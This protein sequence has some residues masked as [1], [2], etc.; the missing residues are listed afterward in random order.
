MDCQ[1]I[2]NIGVVSACFIVDFTVVVNEEIA[3]QGCG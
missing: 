3:L 1:R 2:I